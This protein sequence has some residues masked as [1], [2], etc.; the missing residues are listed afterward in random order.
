[1]PVVTASATASSISKTKHTNAY[2]V[3]IRP[4]VTEKAAHLQSMRQYAFVVARNANKIQIKQAVKDLYQVDPIAI[5]VVNVQ[6]KRLR[7]G[8][9]Q[10]K[11]SDF[12]KA[13]VTLPVG[14]N[15][16]MHEGV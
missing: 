6:G 4:L 2:H 3:I 13:I 14:Q 15:I 10:G 7:F 16:I 9:G 8:K 1:M 11:R 5:N 12:K